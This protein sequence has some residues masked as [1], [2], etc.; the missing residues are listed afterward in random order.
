[1][2][3]RCSF[4]RGCTVL[5]NSFLH[6][7]QDILYDFVFYPVCFP[8]FNLVICVPCAHVQVVGEAVDI[9]DC[10]GVRAVVLFYLAETPLCA[11][12]HGSCHVQAGGQF[13]S[14]VEDEVLDAGEGV[15]DPVDLFFQRFCLVL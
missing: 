9:L 11:S 14:A 10:F 12:G 15:L 6:I 4:F 5:N 1:M 3:K 8:V 7:P 13:A 2:K